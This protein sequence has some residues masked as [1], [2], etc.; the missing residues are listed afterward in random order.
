LTS[1]GVNS[2]GSSTSNNLLIDQNESV[3]IRSM[4]AYEE[5]STQAQKLEALRGGVVI[6]LALNQTGSKFL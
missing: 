1:S 2:N 4:S 3:L 5:A 6:K